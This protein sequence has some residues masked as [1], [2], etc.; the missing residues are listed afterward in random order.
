MALTSQLQQRQAQH[1]SMTPQLRQAIKMLQLNNVELNEFIEQESL[2][3]PLL[4]LELSL[5]HI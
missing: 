2:Q 4:E 1:L 5:I 3:N